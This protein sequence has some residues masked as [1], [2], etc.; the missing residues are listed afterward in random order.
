VLS[1][2]E[3]D[4]VKW[5]HN[6]DLLDA[7]SAPPSGRAAAHEPTL[8]YYALLDELRT[9]HPGVAW[10]SCASGG[11]RIDLGVV[12][13]VQRFWTSDLTDALARQRIQ[14]W[15]AQLI[16]PEYLGAH[17]SAPVSHQTGRSFSLDFRAA[18]AFFGAFGVEW[19][20]TT[21]TET[22]LERLRGWIE[23]HKHWRPTMHGGVVVRCDGLPDDA[24]AHGVI[25]QDRRRALFA[26]VQLDLPTRTRPVQ[27]RI[28]GLDPAVRYRLSYVDPTG[29]KPW[30]GVPVSGAALA[31]V[32]VS[33]PIPAPL[34]VTLLQLVAG[35]AAD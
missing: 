31:Q 24:L 12:E 3:I 9:R 6:R 1:A 10:E 25:A 28:P 11:G 4:Y 16:A 17:V 20:L 27:L 35:D 19:D 26:Y 7:G 33:L 15:T 22:E 21:A 5:D 18:T 2:Y 34:T 30:H 8:A 14:R 13:R 32:G 23:L 29:E